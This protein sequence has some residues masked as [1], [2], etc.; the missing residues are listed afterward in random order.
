MTKKTDRSQT[1]LRVL[2]QVA[3]VKGAAPARARSITLEVEVSLTVGVKLRQR[4][5]LEAGW[6]MTAINERLPKGQ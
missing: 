2:G 6:Q 5:M 3:R 4:V 1:M